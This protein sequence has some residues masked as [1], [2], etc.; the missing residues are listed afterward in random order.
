M[1][2][3]GVL[4]PPYHLNRSFYCDYFYQNSGSRYSYRGGNCTLG[5]YCGF[6][7]VVLSY[8]SGAA[9]WVRGA[10]ISFKQYM[11]YFYQSS[12]THYS[13][14]GGCS[15]VGLYCGNFCV[16]LGASVS[17]T[18]WDIGAALSFKHNSLFIVI[19]FI[20]VLVQCILF[21]VVIPI[22]HLI[23]VFS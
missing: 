18:G 14:R 7:S 4:A 5:F 1:V 10:T 2:F 13:L 19:I 6:T 22:R 9:S 12:G 15:Y 8:D 20:K 21:V 17:S 3:I 16:H 11:Y 23:V